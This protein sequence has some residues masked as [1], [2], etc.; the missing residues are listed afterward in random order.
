MK[1]QPLPWLL[2]LAA[3]ACSKPS[4]ERG[5]LPTADAPPAP[6]AATAAPPAAASAP[7][8]APAAAFPEALPAGGSPSPVEII[9]K[10]PTQAQKGFSDRG[11]PLS[12]FSLAEE[13]GRFGTL[14][15]DRPPGQCDCVCGG[16]HACARCAPRMIEPI[17]LAPGAEQKIAWNGLLRRHRRTLQGNCHDTFAPPAGQYWVSPGGTSCGA[18][19]IT[20][21]ATSPIV[22]ELSDAKS[23]RCDPD[24]TFTERV[25]R[26][27][28][29]TMAGDFVVTKSPLVSELGACDPTGAGPAGA[30]TL[31]VTTGKFDSEVRVTLGGRT[32]ST[33]FDLPGISVVRVHY[34]R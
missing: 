29:H 33:F 15:F 26:L 27:A 31:A 5:A 6:P 11:T 13:R 14:S 28:L 19:R 21:P 7:P 4:A 2:A 23:A 9:V 24:P 12:G 3:L 30:C 25:S 17:P 20:L 22:I 18:K 16:T 32:F 34:Q 10:N 1:K 8:A